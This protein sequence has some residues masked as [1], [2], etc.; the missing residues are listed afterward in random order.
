MDTQFKINERIEKEIEKIKSQMV[1]KYNPLDIILFGSCAKG[2]A[3]KS[4]DIDLC[5]I[6]ETD[7][8]R[9]TLAEMLVDIGCEMDLDIVIYTPEEWSTHKDDRATLAGVIN[10]TGVSLLGR[11]QKI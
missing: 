5:V 4:S 1:D 2:L 8:K 7:N 3:G 10:R 6:L 9:R 11:F